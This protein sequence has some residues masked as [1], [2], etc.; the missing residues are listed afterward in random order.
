MCCYLVSV[1]CSAH[2]S[3]N[4][5]HGPLYI[6]ITPATRNVTVAYYT[7]LISLAKGSQKLPSSC[8][9]TFVPSMIAALLTL[10]ELSSIITKPARPSSILLDLIERLIYHKL[11][12][13][14][15]KEYKLIMTNIVLRQEAVG[16]RNLEVF[17]KTIL[18]YCIKY[19]L[20]WAHSE[21]PL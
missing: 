13:L 1:S 19:G 3:Y 20:G 15:M 11:Q 5:E 10:D 4:I 21:T 18:K 6:V 16:P 7:N 14:F 12:A 9:V 17:M 2:D 8:C